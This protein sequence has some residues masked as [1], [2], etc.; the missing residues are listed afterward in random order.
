MKFRL[1]QPQFIHE[2]GKRNNQEDT[3]FPSAG[4]A[5]AED[6]LFIVCDGMGGHDHGEVASRVVSEALVTYVQEHV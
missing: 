4:T 3:L 5:T 2:I 6:R 1:A